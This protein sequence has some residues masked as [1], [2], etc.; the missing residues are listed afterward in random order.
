LE[1]PSTA[2]DAALGLSAFHSAVARAS[3]NGLL[4]L[5]SD[6]LTG[7]IVALGTDM[8]G[9]DLK[10][11]CAILDQAKSRRSDLVQAINE[12][13][14]DRSA[15]CADDYHRH[16]MGLVT[17]LP[18]AKEIRLKDPQFRSLLLQLVRGR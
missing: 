4:A 3:N 18:K 16:A 17:S 15:R 12:G 11:W 5:I 9:R 14:A 6:F 8:M 1:S 7:L 2:E 10:S 13:D